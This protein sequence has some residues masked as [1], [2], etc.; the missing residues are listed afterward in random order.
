MKR[1]GSLPF[2]YGVRLSVES[3]VVGL[4]V[5]DRWDVCQG[6]VQTPGVVPIDPAGGGV[7]DVGDGLVGALVEHRRECDLPNLNCRRHDPGEAR[8]SSPTRDRDQ[9]NS[10]P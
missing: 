3:S 8:S 5:L 6:A 9:P 2:L 4:L 7:L 10:P 1:P